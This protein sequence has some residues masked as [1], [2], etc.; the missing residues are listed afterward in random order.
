MRGKRGGA[1][2]PP[3]GSG[4][5]FQALTKKLGKKKGVKNPKALAASIGA[6]KLGRAKMQSLAAK[7]KKK[8][9]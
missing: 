5:R 6:K 7:G 4:L 1:E 3:L 9:G 8:R 2:Y